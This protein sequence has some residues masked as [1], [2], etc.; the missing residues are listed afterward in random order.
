MTSLKCQLLSCDLPSAKAST[1]WG[2]LSGPDVHYWHSFN[3]LT[4]LSK[5]PELGTQ[6]K[7]GM[8][9]PAGVLCLTDLCLVWS[10]ASDLEVKKS[11]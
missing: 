6:R 4:G 5:A 1:L 3:A 10:N 7:L 11:A 9:H 2:I 8:K